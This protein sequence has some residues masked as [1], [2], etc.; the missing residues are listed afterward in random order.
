MHNSMR[1]PVTRHED[2]RRILTEYISDIPFKRAKVIESKDKVTVGNHYHKN[3][4]SVFYVLKGKCN[5]H[6]KS[7]HSTTAKE[8]RGWLFE[9]D[10]L[11]VSRGIIHTFNLLP[12][13]I[14]LETAT[15]PYDKKDEISIS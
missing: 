8:S 12:E 15:E 1:L 9:G 7:A 3:N 14:M 4:D 13:T 11:F 6:L 2:E 10:C 5:Y